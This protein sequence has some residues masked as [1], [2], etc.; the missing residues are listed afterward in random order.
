MKVRTATPNLRLKNLRKAHH[1]AQAELAVA[2]PV[3]Q[4][5]ISSI[6]NYG[7]LPS[8]EVRDRIAKVFDVDVSEIWPEDEMARA[9]RSIEMC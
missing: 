8:A 4:R 1:M 2:G 7:Y 9:E 5:L 3:S 6:E